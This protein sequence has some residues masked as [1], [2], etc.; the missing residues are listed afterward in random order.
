MGSPTA[1]SD[2]TLGDTEG[3]SEVHSYFK[4]LY[5]A[6]EQSEATCFCETPV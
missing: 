6:K 2:L 5:L 1:I 4:A 3:Q